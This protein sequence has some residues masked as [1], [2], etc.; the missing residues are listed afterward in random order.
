MRSTGGG[1]I[2]SEVYSTRINAVEVLREVAL[3]GKDGAQ[4]LRGASVDLRQASAKYG[5]APSAKLYA[6]YA[7]LVE[8]VSLLADWRSGVLNA[9]LDSARFLTAAKARA[10]EWK[11]S[12]ADDSALSAFSE[13]SG[14][15]EATE[16]I[17]EVAKVASRLATTPMPIGLHSEFKPVEGQRQAEPKHREKS[18][19]SVAFLKFTVDGIPLGQ[20]HYLSPGEI[21]DLDIEVRVSRWPKGATALVIE[22]ITVER[23]STYQMPIFSIAAPDGPGPHQLRQQG[24]AMLQVPHHMNARPFEF[25]YAA[26]FVPATVEQ[27]VEVVGQR[28][29]L[30]E[31]VD[32]ARSPITGYANLDRKFLQVRDTLRLTPGLSQDEVADA[33]SLAAPIA[34]YAGQSVQDNLFD[35]TLSEAEFQKRLKSFLRSQPKIGSNLEEHPR[36][37]GGITDL[38]YKGIRLEL[39]S[40]ADRTFT[41]KD[42]EAFVAQTASYAVASGKRL[43]ILC[44]LDCSRKQEAPFPVEDGFDVVVHQVGSSLTFIITILIQGNL[45]KPSSL[46]RRSKAPS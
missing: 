10:S 33:L 4:R 5:D 42:C 25:K 43:A 23:F 15:I 37:G 3:G 36:A 28:T 2:H 6:A 22:P 45:A 12:Y 20:I 31:G 11:A 26:K 39:K 19:L 24:R 18:A 27:P 14:F 35:T 38:S 30:L 41:L 32:L 44:V 34:N 9:G 1:E 13:V 7:D 16:D 17:S 46:S 8:M 40:V 21:H 29:L